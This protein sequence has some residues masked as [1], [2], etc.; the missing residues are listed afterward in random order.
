MAHV[1]HHHLTGIMTGTHPVAAKEQPVI[2]ALAVIAILLA[3]VAVLLIRLIGALRENTI[4]AGLVIGKLREQTSSAERLRDAVGHLTEVME[5]RELV[6][7]ELDEQTV[8]CCGGTGACGPAAPVPDAAAGV[9]LIDPP[10][11]PTAEE[12]AQ[13]E[14]RR[15]DA[16]RRAGLAIVDKL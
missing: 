6:M 4:R 13:A 8:G 16:Q 10:Y 9:T 5:P 3:V 11:M 15:L 1:R 7:G 12:M 2:I 14:Q